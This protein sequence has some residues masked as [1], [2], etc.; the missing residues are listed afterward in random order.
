M[1]G[2]SNIHELLGRNLTLGVSTQTLRQ[3]FDVLKYIE[4]SCM[5]ANIADHYWISSDDSLFVCHCET[6]CTPSNERPGT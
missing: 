5:Q 6:L 3:S 2:H 1:T 4:I